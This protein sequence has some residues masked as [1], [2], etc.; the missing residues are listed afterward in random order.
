M[1]STSTS[2]HRTLSAGSAQKEEGEEG[3][4]FEFAVK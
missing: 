3:E 2:T 1:L 4:E